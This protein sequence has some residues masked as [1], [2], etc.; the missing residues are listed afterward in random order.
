MS[1][2]APPTT[3]HRLKHPYVLVF[4][5]SFCLMV[6]E[7]VAGRIMAPTL[8]VSLY[9]W[10]SIIAVILSGITA[11]NYWG[12]RLA[13]AKASPGLLG[14]AFF[15]SGLTCAM[16]LYSATLLHQLFI[17]SQLNLALAT[18][19][20]SLLAFFPVAFFLS[21]ITPIV[22][23]LELDSITKTGRTVGS[24]YATS[25]FGS[26]VGTL[27]TGY[28]LIDQ[29]GTKMIIIAVSVLL[30]GIG[31][32]LMRHGVLWGRIGVVALLMLVGLGFIPVD[33][34]R[35]SQYYCIQIIP[36]NNAHGESGNLIRLDHLIHSYVYLDEKT[37][38]KSFGYPNGQLYAFL[39]AHRYQPEDSFSALFMGGG[40]YVEPRY[41]EAVYPKSSITVAEID[42]AVTQVNIEKL[43]LS[44]KT[45]IQTINQ[46]ARI[47]LE[48]LPK[49]K[50][51]DMIFG[52]A[53]NDLSV[54]YHLTTKEFITLVRSHLSEN[55]F[56]AFHI[57][58][59]YKK[60]RFLA[61]SLRTMQESFPYVYL[62]PMSNEWR[63]I[64]RNTFMIIGSQKPVD[65]TK[66][67]TTQLP[68]NIENLN[69][70]TNPQRSTILNFSSPETIKEIIEHQR[71]IV[72][73]DD[74]APVDTMVTPVFR[75][76][77]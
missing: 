17:H 33:C 67:Q 1:D 53:F 18:I 29:F 46:D 63:T 25:A 72:L 11:G 77:F 48:R 36:T 62:A 56:Y 32:W 26:I 61:S 28:I 31:A 15:I 55:G 39:I 43:G 45:R 4:T 27:T 2:Q 74:Y 3:P 66:L 71:G 73:T 14:S 7:L 54:P 47:M 30:V 68:H 20:F 51:F 34:L 50:K 57:I 10:T 19:E 9:S 64:K 76:A 16:S 42:P 65:L 35:E 69:D 8:G 23:T 12:G 49:D 24:V 6:I 5:G 37:G 70:S 75:S 21:F 58:D 38:I 60:G 59:Q 40:G 22:I 41:V 44:N 13:D 52:D